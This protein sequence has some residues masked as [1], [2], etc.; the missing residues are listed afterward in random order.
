MLNL[1]LL[2]DSLHFGHQLAQLLLAISLKLADDI[3]FLVLEAFHLCLSIC[4]NVIDYLMLLF[5]D[6]P[7]HLQFQVLDL[8][9]KFLGFFQIRILSLFFE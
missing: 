3:N 4:Y 7:A 9:S 2:L 1:Q 5:L 6:V 8:V